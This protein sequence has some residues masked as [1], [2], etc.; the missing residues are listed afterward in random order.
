[1]MD[2]GSMMVLV[3]VVGVLEVV[4]GLSKLITQSLIKRAVGE[5]GRGR[6]GRMK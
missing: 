5:E 1:M 4:N 2:N 6:Y 3:E